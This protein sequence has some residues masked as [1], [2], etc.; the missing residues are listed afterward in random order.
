[1]QGYQHTYTH[2]HIRIL[3]ESTLHSSLY[4]CRSYTRSWQIKEHE[5]FWDWS[6]YMVKNRHHSPLLHHSSSPSILPCYI[7]LCTSVCHSLHH[8][9]QQLLRPLFPT[10]S[11][12]CHTTSPHHSPFTNTHPSYPLTSHP[13]PP[14]LCPDKRCRSMDLHPAHP[15]RHRGG[16]VCGG[17]TIWL[18]QF[19]AFVLHSSLHDRNE[20]V[21]VSGGRGSERGQ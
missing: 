16:G 19:F 7:F 12:P 10:H 5:N 17:H 2:K 20:E 9:F 1:M 6:L 11:H 21:G 4:S 8:P 13:P 15:S 3:C 18:V 14:A